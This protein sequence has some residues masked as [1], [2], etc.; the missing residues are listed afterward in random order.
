MRQA[1]FGSLT[2][3]LS[4]AALA[5]A[6]LHPVFAAST[7]R[8]VGFDSGAISGYRISDVSY[9]PDPGNIHRIAGVTF[10]LDA[11]ARTAEASIGSSPAS[12]LVRG[13]RATCRFADEPLVETATSLE[14]SAA[15]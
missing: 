6:F 4:G 10:R 3:V 1:V 9:L 13:T 5:G 12:C 11:P 7:P 15:S 8:P 2:T 14:V